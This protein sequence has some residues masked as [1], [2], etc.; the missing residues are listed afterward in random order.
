MCFYLELFF[1]NEN[2]SRPQIKLFLTG[3]KKD[4]VTALKYCLQATRTIEWSQ[5]NFL[6][7]W[8]RQ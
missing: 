3:V 5:A 8:L 7:L 4:L 2:L 1:L 6:L